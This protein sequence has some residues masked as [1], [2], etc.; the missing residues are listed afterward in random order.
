VAIG[1]L[2]VQ[3]TIMTLGQA[4]GTA[5]HLCLELGETPRGIYERH[6]RTLQQ[7]LIRHDQYIPDFKNED[8]N[9]VCL[10]AEV[11]ASSVSTTEIYNGKHGVDGPLL[12]L[13]EVRST[14]F[15][16][17]LKHKSIAQL[18][19]KLHS[20][21]AEPFPVTLHARTEG[22]L[23][24][25]PQPGPEYTAQAMV[26]P[27]CEGWVGFDIN[28]PLDDTVTGGY[29]RVWLDKA[30]G[31]SWRSIE[32]LSLYHQ[33]GVMG[34]NGKW[35]SEICK[36]YHVLPK[37]PNEPIANCAPENAIN[38]LSRIRSAEVYE[39]VSDPAQA[40][41]QWLALDFAKPTEI[42]S[43]SVVFNTD[44]TNPGPFRELKSPVVS[45]CV[46][47]YFVEI[48]GDGKWI[49]IADVKDNFMR[50]RIH[51]FENTVVEKIRVTVTATNGDPSARITEVRAALD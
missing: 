2:R 19:V 42:N 38:G 27:M 20:S 35:I 30:E 16:I 11:T 3:N 34:E 33:R 37:A 10:N 29:L 44:M 12:P 45:L 25:T 14:V 1:T 41:P 46:K 31:I 17:S 32:N 8:E 22:D 47:D 26:P 4:A 21:H 43:V 15:G 9:D 49:K 36:S 40:M 6:I 39:W 51:T 23:D 24:T 13:D 48:F 50:K 7:L 5:A 28:L 18:Y